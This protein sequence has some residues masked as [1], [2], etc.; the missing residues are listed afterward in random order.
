MVV[1]PQSLVKSRFQSTPRPMREGDVALPTR[2][3]AF[4]LLIG[5]AT[6][7]PCQE[8]V[9]VSNDSS[10]WTRTQDTW[11][12]STASTID[13]RPSDEP[14]ARRN[15]KLGAVGMDSRLPRGPSI[16]RAE[17][18]HELRTIPTIVS[19]SKLLEKLV[20]DSRDSRVRPTER[21]K[22]KDTGVLVI[23]IS[24]ESIVHLSCREM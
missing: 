13:G 1:D 9:S 24:R 18:I 19:Y 5:G 14:R 23:E 10:G 12:S 17:S 3:R 2:T 15:L 8:P 16:K 22:E 6:C 21:Q 20:S 11:P 7:E 4:S